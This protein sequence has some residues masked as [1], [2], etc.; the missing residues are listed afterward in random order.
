MNTVNPNE[1]CVLLVFIVPYGKAEAILGYL[2][3]HHESG[4][5]VMYGKGT[6]PG[7]LLDL[8]GLAEVRREI[9]LIVH[10]EEKCLEIARDVR[11]EFHLDKQGQGIAFTIPIHQVSG[12]CG[13]E[14]TQGSSS[15]PILPNTEYV[16]LCCILDTGRSAEAVE[17]ANRAGAAGAT[18]IKAKG[19]A[20]LN[21]DLYEFEIEAEKEIILMVLPKNELAEVEEALFSEFDLHLENKGILYSYPITH[22]IGLYGQEV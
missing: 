1:N 5:T 9:L 18:V 6:R 15:T 19:L 12:T 16:A 10:Q 13:R 11:R 21:P 17:V 2:H 22:V 20:E 14:L 4:A 8:L 3:D 7:V